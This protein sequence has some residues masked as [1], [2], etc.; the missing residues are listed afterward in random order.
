MARYYRPAKSVVEGALNAAG[1]TRGHLNLRERVSLMAGFNDRAVADEVDEAMYMVGL[2][3][4]EWDGDGIV[5]A[6]LEY[7]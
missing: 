2:E 4:R 3:L 1:H 7:V 6:I 5:S